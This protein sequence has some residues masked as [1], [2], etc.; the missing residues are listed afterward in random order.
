VPI[1]RTAPFLFNNTEHAA[2]LFALK[3]LGPWCPCSTVHYSTVQYSTENLHPGSPVSSRHAT[4]LWPDRRRWAGA[5][6]IYTRL[7]NPTTDI[8]EK[9]VSLLEVSKS[10]ALRS[11]HC[12]DL[13]R[14]AICVP[15]RRWRRVP[16]I[17]GSVGVCPLTQLWW[18]RWLFT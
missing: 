10:S 7:M 17:V 14:G 16:Y 15:Q 4:C 2:N 1:Y 6:N 11:T 18:I 9:R 5:G 3:E 13:R 12:V 8:L